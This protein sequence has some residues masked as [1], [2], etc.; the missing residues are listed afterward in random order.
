MDVTTPDE[1]DKTSSQT[2]LRHDGRQVRDNDR[3]KL[4]DVPKNRVDPSRTEHERMESASKSLKEKPQTSEE[5]SKA[6]HPPVHKSSPSTQYSRTKDF[7]SGETG[8]SVPQQSSTFNIPKR[9]DSLDTRLHQTVNRKELSSS[10]KPAYGQPDASGGAAAVPDHTR[11]GSR[12]GDSFTSSPTPDSITFSH[13]RGGSRNELNAPVE[14]PDTSQSAAALLRYS[15]IGDFSMDEDMARILGSGDEGRDQESF[16]RRV[17]NSVR[18]GRSYSDKPHRLSKEPKWPKSPTNANDQARD[19]SSPIGSSP[20]HRDELAQLKNELRRERQKVIE[21]DRKIAE[22]EGTLNATA[23]IKRVNSELSEKRSTMV[24]LD[25][26]KEMMVRELE[27]LTGR[28]EAEK[29]SGAP[30]DLR[31]LNNTV[32]RDFAESL[33]RT[34]W[35]LRLKS[36]SRSATNWSRR[37][38][39]LAG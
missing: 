1:I 31:K 4:Q 5:S 28:I 39:L 29:Q 19:M 36:W 12:T 18:H 21:K 16:L 30:L 24:F 37:M 11:T 2:S 7:D 3:F 20:D 22:L 6:A 15:T 8:A 9:G 35:P 34:R 23:S 38:L 10:S 25:S 17:S 32:L 33:R 13:N 14:L 27:V 26:Q